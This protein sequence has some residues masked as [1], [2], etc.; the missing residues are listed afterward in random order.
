MTIDDLKKM[1]EKDLQIDKAALD[2]E[3]LKTPQLHNKYLNFFHDDRI[4]LRKLKSARDLL[5]RKKWEY[6]SGKLSEEELKS[7]GWEP[8]HLKIL[9]PDLEIYMNSDVE[10][11]KLNEKIMVL[12]ERIFLLESTIKNIMNR[13]WHI[14]GAIDWIKFTNGVV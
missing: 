11:L 7:L 1:I 9:K 14:R 10:L 5:Y 13:Q 2:N 8:F 4:N 12:E 3:S 6:Y